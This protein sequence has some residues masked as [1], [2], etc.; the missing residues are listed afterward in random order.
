MTVLITVTRRTFTTKSTISTWTVTRGSEAQELCA[1]IEDV[2]R[3]LDWRMSRDDIAA[4]KV[5]GRTAIPTGEYGV[6]MTHS[7]RFRTTLPLLMDVRGYQGVRIHAGNTAE[8]TEGCLL[9]GLRVEVDR[10]VESRAALIAVEAIILAA[11]RRGEAVRIRITRDAE[12]WASFVGA[13]PEI[14]RDA[15]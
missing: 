3:G 11:A 10:V 2:D 15:A 9:P 1:G 5:H 7:P 12:A 6:V 4:R 13:H 14:V 8:D